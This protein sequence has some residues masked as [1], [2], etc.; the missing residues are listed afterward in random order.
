MKVTPTAGRIAVKELEE[1][2]SGNAVSRTYSHQTGQLQSE[3]GEGGKLCKCEVL[4]VGPTPKGFDPPG[5]KKGGVVLV[6]D[7]AGDEVEVDGEDI[8]LIS[9]YD[10]VGKVE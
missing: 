9:P 4:E 7:Y 6:R 10:I 3:P 8:C 2:G 5:V 1:P